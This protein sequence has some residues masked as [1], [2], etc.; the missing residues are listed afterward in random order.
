[1]FSPELTFFS[2]FFIQ[3]PKDNTTLI[4]IHMRPCAWICNSVRTRQPLAGSMRFLRP[5]SSA[6]PQAK[7]DAIRW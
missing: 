1:M 4:P 5:A 2:D 6:E 7:I 3:I